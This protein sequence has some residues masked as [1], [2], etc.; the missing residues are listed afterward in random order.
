MTTKKPKVS[1]G[2]PVYNGEAYVKDA[3]DSVLSQ[4]FADFELIIS[5]NASIDGTQVICNEY[6][7]KD[8]RV[9]YYRSKENRGAAWNYNRTFELSSGEYFRW[10]AAD[11]MLAPG[12]LARSVQ[13]L[14]THQEVVLCFSWT[15]DIDAAGNELVTKKSTV[16]SNNSQ[17]SIRFWN[18]SQARPTHNCE[19][20]FGLIRSDIL[21]E[22]KLIDYYTDSDRTLLAHLALYGPFYE[23][24]EPLFW[25]RIHETSSVV[26]NPDRHERMLWFDPSLAG[27][28]YFPN[29]RQLKELFLVIGKDS[30]LPIRERILCYLYVLRW[31]KRRYR[32]LT[33]DMIWAVRQLGSIAR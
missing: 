25:H 15:K 14:E 28:L 7:E 6:A 33:N 8:T 11:D 19:E 24:P 17:P 21:A 20:V 23:I 31:A 5:D 32:F 4:T 1:I 10:L 16:R 26:V 9:K 3:I 22:T 27:R 18:L 30:S 29:W 12:L 13:I 2:L